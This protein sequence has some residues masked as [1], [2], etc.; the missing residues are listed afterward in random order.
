[1]VQPT[2]DLR[3]DNSTEK[4]ETDSRLQIRARPAK[5]LLQRQ[6]QRAECIQQRRIHID[7][8]T[9]HRDDENAPAQFEFNQ[10]G[11]AAAHSRTSSTLPP[12]GPPPAA[13]TATWQSSIWRPSARPHNCVQASCT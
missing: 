4:H 8:D 9:E 6:Y 12:S 11:T 3:T 10:A 5:C 7:A 13:V 1:M 2:D